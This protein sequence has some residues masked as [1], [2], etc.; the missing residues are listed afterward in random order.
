M[1]VVRI[2][3]EIVLL[4]LLTNTA[5]LSPFPHSAYS[6]VHYHLFLSKEMNVMFH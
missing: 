6:I 2:I 4:S 3:T 1:V 5:P